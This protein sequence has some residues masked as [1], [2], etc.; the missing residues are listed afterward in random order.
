VPMWHACVLANS[1]GLEDALLGG[2]AIYMHGAVTALGCDIL[3]E[4]VPSDALDVMC[5]FS[6]FVHAFSCYSMLRSNFKINERWCTISSVKNS[7]SV[8]RTSSDDVLP[9]RTPGQVIDLHRGTSM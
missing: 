8:V 3:V 2:D 5:V 7:G 1:V 6:N 4:R 9:G